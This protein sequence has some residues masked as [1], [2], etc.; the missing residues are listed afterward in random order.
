[1]LMLLADGA[2]G[3]S[4]FY[5]TPM[6]DEESLKVIHKAVELCKGSKLMIDSKSSPAC[7]VLC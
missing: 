6:D 5:G 2:M 7:Y 4:A 3:L 1:M